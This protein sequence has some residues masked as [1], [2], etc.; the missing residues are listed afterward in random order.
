MPAEFRPAQLWRDFVYLLGGVILAAIWITLLT[1]LLSLGLGLLV[2]I[3]GFPILALT[4]LLWRWGADRERERA[5]LV[6][7]AP[8]S[9]YT[10]ST[11]P[12]ATSPRATSSPRR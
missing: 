7:G 11:P 4:L 3:V 8:M 5:T 10:R 1:T 2:V 12:A 6:L 9:R